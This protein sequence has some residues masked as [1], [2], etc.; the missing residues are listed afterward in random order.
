M[1][2]YLDDDSANHLLV[3]LI[4]RAGHDV[5]IPA[6][7]SLSGQSDAVHLRNGIRCGRVCL[8][9]NHEDFQELHDLVRE[10]RGTHPGLLVV[11][12]DNDRKR[13]LTPA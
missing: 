7:V 5:Q 13:D 1:L 2:L 11:R 8:T 12:N 4:S 9:Q 6:D 3:K 10:A